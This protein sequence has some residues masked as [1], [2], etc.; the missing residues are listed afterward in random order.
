MLASDQYSQLIADIGATAELYQRPAPR[1][2]AVSKK[3][4]AEAIRELYTQGQRDFGESYWQ[5][6]EQKLSALSDLAIQWHF[7]GPLQSNKTG[8]IANYFQWVH[9]LDREK[10]AHRLNAARSLDLPPLNVCIQVNIDQESAKS[11]IL[12]QDLMA[13]AATIAD[14]PRLRLRGLMCIPKPNTEF[15]LQ[16][17]A[18]HRLEQLQQQLLA[19]GFKV[20]TLSMG[21]SGDW[22][23]AIAEGSTIIRLGTAIFGPRQKTAIKLS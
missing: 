1:L 15:E 10:I 13:L 20:D 18:F 6:A 5:E 3:Q 11:G 22:Q 7:I 9:S 12:P 2:L 8:V 14:L 16:R 17:H 19:E 23:A 4:P 21:M